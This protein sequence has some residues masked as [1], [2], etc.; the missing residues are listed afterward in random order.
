MYEMNN[1]MIYL[2]GEPEA[3]STAKYYHEHYNS[4]ER[5]ADEYLHPVWKEMT[6]EAK[7][8][9]HDGIDGI[10]FRVF[11]DAL[12]ENRPMPIDVYDA[13]AW[14]SVTA[15]SES[16]IAMGGAPQAIPDFTSGAW[17]KR[18]PQDVLEL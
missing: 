6:P 10:E 1:N 2:A 3:F 8:L 13:A 18:A 17:V 9:G 12:R 16:S 14:M 7:R 11:V 4:I 5:F 15:L